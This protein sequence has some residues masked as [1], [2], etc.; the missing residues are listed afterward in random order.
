[1]SVNLS[2]PSEAINPQ[3]VETLRKLL[4]DLRTKPPGS[5]MSKNLAQIEEA[6]DE[7]IGRYGPVFSPPNV[8]NLS[9]GTF[10]EFLRFE[11]NRHWTGLGRLGGKLT[12]DMDRLRAALG[13]LVE[14]IRPLKERLDRLRPSGGS[15]MVPF[16]GRA[17]LT[18]ILHLVYPDRYG[19]VNNT[20]VRG[21]TKLGL[22]PRGLS[23]ASLAVQYETI[24][25]VLLELARRLDIDLWTLDEL[26]WHLAP[27]P[28]A[29]SFGHEPRA[30][31]P[32]GG[33]GIA[34]S[35][36]SGP[37]ARSLHVASPSFTLPS[38]L[39]F[40]LAQA[41][42]RLKR[43]CR[44]EFA[45][46]DGIVDLVPSRVE[47]IDVLA[48]VSM[49]SFVNKASLIRS[50]HRALAGCCD[51]LLPG[52]PVNADLMACDPELS[53]FR[54][55]M[56]AAIQA[57]GVLVPVATKVLHRKRRSYIPML[58]SLVIKHYAAAANR[59]D[60]IEQSQSKATAAA[61]AVEIAKAFRE[62]LRQA[63]PELIPIRTSLANAGFG[64]TPVRIL[65]VLIWTQI[66]PNGYYRTG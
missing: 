4:D 47:P 53:Q 42:S 63:M 64:L 8:A 35:L 38:G 26:W 15:A 33:S 9:R 58:D 27:S 52:I 24:N 41:E 3:A 16:L 60:W 31:Q 25:P 23:D 57:P 22:W 51:P 20:L 14:E 17:V 61:V 65:E 39:S 56:H 36:D 2:N 21:M 6:R 28:A 12:K 13:L 45:Y 30:T 48:S 11:N 55:L 43:F 66:E 1:M 18:A 32:M 10:L 49:N 59:P 19:V 62:D 37:D 54:Q 5:D 40:S 44:E 7:V 29:E 34:R 50:V 46:Y